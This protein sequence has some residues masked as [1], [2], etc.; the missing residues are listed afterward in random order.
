MSNIYKFHLSER[1]TTAYYQTGYP[2][3][4]DIKEKFEEFGFECSAVDKPYGE[5]NA[6]HFYVQINDTYRLDIT[7]NGSSSIEYYIADNSSVRL[8][9]IRSTR[10][11]SLDG[12]QSDVYMCL[13]MIDDNVVVGF[14]GYDSPIYLFSLGFLKHLDVDCWYYV[15]YNVTTYDY[16]ITLYNGAQGIGTLKQLFNI[17]VNEQYKGLFNNMLLTDGSDYTD[18]NHPV[19][20]IYCIKTSYPFNNYSTF[21]INGVE[22]YALN[23][24]TVLR[25]E[26]GTVIPNMI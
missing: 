1:D 5:N 24:W 14:N 20:D 7:T 11:A 19:A 3:A 16:T 4:L 25:I 13:I 26:A 10:I 8:C 6:G 23:K 17:N 15:P 9:D 21:K 2:I 22:F 12:Y 18:I